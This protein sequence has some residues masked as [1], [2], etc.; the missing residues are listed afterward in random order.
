MPI[1]ITEFNMLLFLD[2]CSYER[3][4][5]MLQNTEVQGSGFTMKTLNLNFLTSGL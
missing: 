3:I 2:T 5:V 1:S 4:I